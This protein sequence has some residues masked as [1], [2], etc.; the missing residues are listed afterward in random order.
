MKTTPDTTGPV[1]FVG[2]PSLQAVERLEIQILV[3]NVTDTLSSNP[4]F[5]K[6][7]RTCLVEKGME[8]WSGEA[9]CCAHFGLSLLLTTHHNGARRT[10]LFDGGPEGYAI[11]R[12]GERLKVDF[13][14]VEGVVL[15]HGHWD[16]AGGLDK[17]LELIHG[18]NGGREVPYYLHPG[19]FRQ[20]GM[21]FPTGGV[22]PFKPIPDPESLRKGGARPHLSS[23]ASTV[24]DNTYFISGEIPRITPYEQ[25]L[26]RHVRRTEDGAGWEPD[27]LIMDERFVA[28]HVKEKGLVVFTACSHAGVINVLSEARNRFPGVPI[29]A[30]MG[31]LHLSG[32]GPEKIIPETVRDL[33]GFGLRWIV[34]CHCTGWRAVGALTNAFGE[35]HI[36]PGAVGKHFTF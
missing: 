34:P 21:D 24:L 1:P 28:V 2:P 27:P 19:M 30:V 3:D 6:D 10:L 9:I 23:A 4:D 25:G 35:D 29:H 16:H 26:P 14:A 17:A 12:N 8:E 18:A 32:P 11:E 20:R 22:L 31:G 5:V 7:E 15:S 36:I 33:A 13:G